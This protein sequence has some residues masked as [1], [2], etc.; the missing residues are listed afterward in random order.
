MS[1]SWLKDCMRRPWRHE[2]RARDFRRRVSDCWG[3]V[4]WVQRTH[5][6]REVPD[7]LQEYE[8]AEQAQAAFLNFKQRWT[9]VEREQARQGDVVLL[10][11]EGQLHAGVLVNPR[12]M[13]QLGAGG[14]SLLNLRDRVEG[15][16][17]HE[18][19]R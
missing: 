5:F 14:V 3:F 6:S 16:Y 11:H 1:K 10:N 4:I 17:R 12:Q 19:D 7:Y 15:F 13:I 18:D 9:S 8:D 2:W